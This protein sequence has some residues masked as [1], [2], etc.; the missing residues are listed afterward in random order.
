MKTSRHLI[1]AVCVAALAG[2]AHSI[3]RLVPSQYP[4][5]QAAVNAATAGDSVIVAP[6]DYIESVNLSGK[7]VTVRSVSIGAAAIIAPEGLRSVVA[8]SGEPAETRVIGFRMRRLGSVGGGVQTAGASLTFESCII[9]SCVN[10]AGGAAFVNGG[11]VT[12][13]GCQF[14]ACVATGP[15]G[16]YG[17]AGGLHANGGNTLIEDSLFMQCDGGCA[18]EAILHDGGGAVTVRRTQITGSSSATCF[19]QIYNAQGS[20]LVEDTIFENGNKPA[21]FAWSPFTVRRCV[22]RGMNGFSVLDR[23]GGTY[24]VDACQFVDCHTA[25]P[26]FMSYYSGSFSISNSIF[27]NTT[28][29][30]SMVNGAWTD[31]GG[32]VFDCPCPGDITGGGTVDAT[33]LAALLGAWGTNGEGKFDTDLNND[34]NVDASDLAVVLSGWGPCPG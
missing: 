28:W 9:E 24:T 33:D 31:G 4:T 6:G 30:G 20:L 34:G 11:A 14:V 32:N 15:A 1:L 13:A 7:S 3:D 29:V 21:L 8:V 23:R 2:S 10:P 16:L 17:S 27:C 25:G 18:A 12:F 19:G 5:I 26:L 22:F